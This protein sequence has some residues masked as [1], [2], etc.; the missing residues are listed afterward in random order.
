MK[1]CGGASVKCGREDVLKFC[2]L[3]EV[4][5]GRRCPAGEYLFV[6][7]RKDGSIT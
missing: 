7:V 2:V 6:T 1:L 5:D 4:E 3:E